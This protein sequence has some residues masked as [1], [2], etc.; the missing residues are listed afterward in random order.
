MFV[1]RRTLVPTVLFL[2][3]F[4]HLQAADRLVREME[5]G[6]A[7]AAELRAMRPT[8]SFTNA[9]AF[10]LRDAD[11]NVRR[12]PLT[13]INRVGET[14]DW[15]VIYAAGGPRPET[16]IMT[17]TPDQ[18][19]QYRVR[20]GTGPTEETPGTDGS[21]RPFA[22]SDF[23]LRE[24]GLEFLHWPGQRLQPRTPPPMKKGQACRILES[25]NPDAPVYTRVVSWI[26]IEH[27][28]L[29]LAD[30]Y[31]ASGRLIKRFSIGSLKKVDGV[32]QLRDMEMIDEVRGTETK[33]EFELNSRE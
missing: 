26:S 9:A 19:P 22:G 4:L 15:E 20:T 14:P 13:I 8:E 6:R 3:G 16:L 11:G 33:L 23:T 10:R 2:A 21:A 12:L 7:L 32:W 27:H 29:M 24:L 31:D 28:G 17:R 25:T 30:A 18:P 1:R 5:E